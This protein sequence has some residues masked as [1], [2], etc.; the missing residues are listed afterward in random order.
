LQSVTG[1]QGVAHRNIAG[2]ISEVSEK[3]ATQI[4]K[5]LPSSTTPVSFDTPAKRNSRGYPHTTHISSQWPTFL[6]PI[7]WVYFH[8]NLCSMPQKMPCF[9]RSKSSKVDDFGTNR[10]RI[11]DLLLACHCNYGP[12]LQHF[13]DTATYWL[14]IAYFSYPSLILRPHSLRCLWSF[15]VKL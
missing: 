5:K 14:K 9:C 8:S 10:K 1:C 11:C 2:L 3:V 4:A 12:L 7:A 15:A 13:L 6:S